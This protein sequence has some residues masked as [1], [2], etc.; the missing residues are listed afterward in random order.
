MQKQAAN[1]NGFGGSFTECGTEI[2]AMFDDNG[3]GVVDE[4]EVET[5]D[6][7]FAAGLLSCWKLLEIP[8]QEKAPLSRSAASSS[9]CGN[10]TLPG[11]VRVLLNYVLRKF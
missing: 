5:H 6:E 7:E 4:A 10:E 9:D 2:L 1:A 3:D 8:P 11:F